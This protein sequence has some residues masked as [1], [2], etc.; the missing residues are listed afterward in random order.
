MVLTPFRASQF[1]RA[2]LGHVTKEYPGKLDHVL[3]GPED[4]VAPRLLHPIFF[5]SFDW[6]SCVHAYWL[7]ARLL[8]RCPD[9]AEADRIRDLFASSFTYDNVAVEL[10]YLSRP[11]TR[12]FER[13]YGWAWLLKLAAE[14]HAHPHDEAAQWSVALK[15]LANAFARRFLEYLP[16]AR[17]PIRS[18]VHSNTAFALALAMD[19][20]Q[21]HNDVDLAVALTR[22]AQDWYLDDADCQAWEPGGED[23]LSPCLIEA[24]CMRRMLPP[25]EFNAWFTRFLPRLAQREPSTLFQPVVATDR[26]DG[27]IAHLDGLN[28]SRAWCWNRLA[29]ALPESDSRAAMLRDVAGRHLEA[30]IQHIAEDYM[31]EHW[32]A[33]FAL[34]ALEAAEP[35]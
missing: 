29:S 11:F 26:S 27:K 34:L 6:H 35:D 13:P 21:A 2:A 31:G 10:A 18:G 23:F 4:L 19:Y 33:T 8:R 3:A 15:P 28:L 22:A 20:V 25:E 12:T 14:L 24:E 1:A 32:L 7:L 5:G 16:K 30:S 17:Y 9:L